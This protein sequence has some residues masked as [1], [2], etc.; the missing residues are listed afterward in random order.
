MRWPGRPQGFEVGYKLSEVMLRRKFGTRCCLALGVAGIALTP[1]TAQRSSGD[2]NNFARGATTVAPVDGRGFRIEGTLATL[3]DT[4]IIR[5]GDGLQAPDGRKKGDFRISPSVSAAYGMPI[6]RQQIYIGGLVGRDFYASNGSRN[7]NRYV[8]GGGANLHAGRSCS[9][10]LTGEYQRRQSLF[11]ELSGLTTDNVQE[12]QVYA[13]SFECAPPVGI[14]FGG[15]AQRRIVDNDDPRRGLFDVRENSYNAHANL[16]AGRIGQFSL[17]GSYTTIDYP[18]RLVTLNSAAFD[19]TSDGLNLYSAY[20]GFSRPIGARLSM[21]LQGSYS[22]ANP[23]PR[24]ILQI[25]DLFGQ[26]I[27]IPNDRKGYSG[28]GYSASVSYHPSSR[29]NA[30]LNASHSINNSSNVGALYSVTDLF[31][32]EVSY[33][34]RPSLTAGLGGSYTQRSYR[35]SFSSGTEP[36]ARRDDKSQRVYGRLSYTPAKLYDVDFEVGHERRQST[37]A[38]YSYNSTTAQVTLHVRFGRG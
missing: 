37:P 32:A 16:G 29:L 1:A 19:T 36:I 15:G 22:R 27:G 5:I 12:T 34:L 17:G 18:R 31:G 38:I 10:A 30:D 7:R 28:G 9:G 8:I 25:V 24:N 26:Q 35:G 4:N 33:N 11:S 2:D 6:G 21:S 13:A 20:L 23:Q 14:G 3:Y